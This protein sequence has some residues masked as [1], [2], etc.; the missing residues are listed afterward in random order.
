M[1]GRQ[2][3]T[4][5][6]YGHSGPVEDYRTLQCHKGLESQRDGVRSPR[7]RGGASGDTPRRRRTGQGVIRT[8]LWTTH[9]GEDPGSTQGTMTGRRTHPSPHQIERLEE[10]VGT[11]T[12]PVLIR[13]PRKERTGLKVIPSNRQGDW[14]SEET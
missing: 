8:S 9:L 14:S 4:T 6:Q 11:L 7:V 12:S 1:E 3:S 10:R 2:V 13:T 5:S